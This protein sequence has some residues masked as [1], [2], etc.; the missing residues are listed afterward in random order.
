MRKVVCSGPG[1]RLISEEEELN[2]AILRPDTVL[3]LHKFMTEN[4]L[5]EFGLTVNIS[6]IHIDP[7][8]TTEDFNEAI[9]RFNSRQLLDRDE[10]GESGSYLQEIIHEQGK[11]PTKVQC[12]KIGC[13]IVASIQTNQVIKDGLAN[14]WISDLKIPKLKFKQAFNIKSKHLSIKSIEDRKD[15]MRNRKFKYTVVIFL[16]YNVKQFILKRY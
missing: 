8:K 2:G 11:I 10:I 15:T 7:F 1:L 4:N 3:I 6:S 12:R 13:G 9:S 14:D 16:P 5:G